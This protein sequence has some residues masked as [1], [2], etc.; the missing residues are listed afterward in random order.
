MKVP[1][2]IRKEVK[3]HEEVDISLARNGFGDQFGLNR[4][5]M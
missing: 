4:D 1:M 3:E 5:W 2:S